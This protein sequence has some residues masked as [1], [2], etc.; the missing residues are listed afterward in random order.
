MLGEKI[1]FLDILG[2]PDSELT[3]AKLPFVGDVVASFPSPAGDYMDKALSLDELLIGDKNAT[4]LAR[5]VGSSM[6]DANLE[7]GDIVI[8]ARNLTAIHGSVVIC[9]LN[10]SF[11]CKRLHVSQDPKR[12][13]LVS[14]N[15]AF[16]PI[17]IDSED[18]LIIEG[19]VT[20]VI[21]KISAGKTWKL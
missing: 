13:F 12:V 2:V 5:I 18:D 11:A 16:E 17:E 19:V 10:G 7:D 20:Y 8:I 4:I 14:E 9:R 6:I 3:G 15:K 1:S 21:K